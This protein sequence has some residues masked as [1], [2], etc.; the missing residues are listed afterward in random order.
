MDLSTEYLNLKLSSPIV[1]AASP[2][3]DSMDNIKKMED[4]GISA[5]VLHSLFEE[6]LR[7]EQ[8]ELH[9]A[10]THGTYSSPE[11]LTYF[12]DWDEYNV[13]PEE[14]LE[15]IRRAKMSVEIPIIASLNGATKGSWTEYSKKME[16]AGADAIELNNYYIPCDVTAGAEEIERDYIEILQSV[17]HA[18][19]IPVAVKL[20]PYF[21]NVANMSKKLSESGADGLVLFNRF[22]QAD[23]DLEELVIKPK[24]L[25]STQADM[26]LP[27]TWIGIL[28]GKILTDLAASGGIHTGFDVIKMIMVGADVAMVASALLKY[29]IRHA[30][31]MK[32]EII[33]WMD[34]HEYESIIQM[35]GSMS[36]EKAANPEAY[37]RAHYMKAL[38]SYQFVNR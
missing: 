17:K 13:G 25:L 3:S 8:Y 32:D 21:S 36:Q 1:S 15:L 26:L 2:I 22:Y 35:K 37:E 24:V 11:S 30:N 12:P 28:K 9:Y 4:A 27:M 6:Q 14:Y 34:E 29:G 33:R 38:S 7:R 19:K 16:D 5:I 20:S 10:T 31:V 18:V 23:V